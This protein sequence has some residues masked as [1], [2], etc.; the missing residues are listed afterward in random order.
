MECLFLT[1]PALLSTL[2]VFFDRKYKN[3]SGLFRHPE[4][5]VGTFVHQPDDGIACGHHIL[6]FFLETGEFPVAQVITYPLE[7]LHDIGDE[8][9]ARLPFTDR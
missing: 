9:V 1:S 6:L 2:H 4:A 3:I 5:V 7:M 8:T